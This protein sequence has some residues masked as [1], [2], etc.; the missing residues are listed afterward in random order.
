ML[1]KYITVNKIIKYTG[2]ILSRRILSDVMVMKW[3]SV[4]EHSRWSKCVCSQDL[5]SLS[6]LTHLLLLVKYN[7]VNKYKIYGGNFVLGGIL[8][9]GFCPGGFVRGIL[10]WYPAIL[11]Q[12]VTTGCRKLHRSD[13]SIHNILSLNGHDATNPKIYACITASGKRP[14]QGAGF[15]IGNLFDIKILFHTVSPKW[16]FF[17]KIFVSGHS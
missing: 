9:R 13:W 11:L 14:H 6:L 17:E 1:I 4:A 10:S 8:S 2:G 15:I 5:N 16:K 12:L 7:T 3:W